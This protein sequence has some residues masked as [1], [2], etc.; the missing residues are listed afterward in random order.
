MISRT[1]WFMNRRTCRRYTTYPATHRM[2]AD[3][4]AMDT[5]KAMEV[6][7]PPGTHRAPIGSDGSIVIVSALILCV[8][9]YV[10]YRLHVRRFMNQEVREI[11]QQYMPLDSTKDMIPIGTEPG[12]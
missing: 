1:S 9:G 7:P 4:K 8:A 2:S 6:P 3:T 11:M 10:V 5:T 12:V